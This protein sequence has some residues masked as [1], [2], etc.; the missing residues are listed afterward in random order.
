MPRRNL[1]WLLGVTGV[2]VL[3]YAVSHSAPTREQDQDYSL[4]SLVV[5]S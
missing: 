2:F 3:G 4:V 1:T 5:E